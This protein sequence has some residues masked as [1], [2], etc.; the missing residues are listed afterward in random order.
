M[1]EL[2]KYHNFLYFSLPTKFARE[3]L[4]FSDAMGYMDDRDIHIRRK[5]FNN[6]VIM[7]VCKGTLHVKQNNKHFVLKSGRGI[8]LNLKE[9][10]EYYSD[11]DDPCSIIFTHLNGNY[12]PILVERINE[13]H[14]LPIEFDGAKIQP[15]LLNCFDAIME[16]KKNAEICVSKSLYSA[17]M[18]ILE[19][20]YKE[21]F[22]E[23]IPKKLLINQINSY[24]D[25]HIYEKISL[26]DLASCVNLSK[27]HFCRCFKELEALSPMK[28]VVKK[29]LE[30][31]KFFLQYSGVPIQSIAERYGFADQSHYARQFYKF[32][33]ISPRAYRKKW[34]I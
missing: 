6:N 25:F 27:Y 5:D 16:Q 21:Y 7:I 28:Y 18:D 13:F 29:R 3:Y 19:L 11:D 15:I 4:F 8:F 10:H 1:N 26:E 22:T 17:I 34:Q 30:A 33:A 14:S 23:V 32:N 31:S 2:E 12:C 20:D 9:F 24:I